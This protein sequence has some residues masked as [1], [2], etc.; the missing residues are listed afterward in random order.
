MS[1]LQTL[2]TEWIR[3]GPPSSSLPPAWTFPQ[4]CNLRTLKGQE[5]LRVWKDSFSGRAHGGRPIA[6][7]TSQSA[8]SAEYTLLSTDHRED[9]YESRNLTAPGVEPLVDPPV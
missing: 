1:L 5:G 2:A 9:G 6:S 4:A 7:T 8:G 3:G